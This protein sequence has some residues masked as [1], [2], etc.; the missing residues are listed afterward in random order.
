MRLLI[1]AFILVALIGSRLSG[2]EISTPLGVVYANQEAFFDLVY[3]NETG[4]PVQIKQV[5]VGC[6]CITVL[7]HPTTVTAGSVARI[8]CVYRSAVPGNLQTSVEL[9]GGDATSP[10]AAFK[11]TGFVAE[12]SWLI[13]AREVLA[14]SS[15]QALLVDVRGTEAFAAGHPPHALNLPVFSLKSRAALSSR[16]IVLL[17]EGFAPEA[18]LAEVQVLRE[19]GFKN[20]AVLTGGLVAWVRAGGTLEGT[21]KSATQLSVIAA[22]KFG[23]SNANNPWLCV[24]VGAAQKAKYDSM[25]V[26]QVSTVEELEKKMKE[27]TGPVSGGLSLRMVLVIAEPQI[28]ARIENRFGR[29]QSQQLFYLD[30]GRAALESYQSTQVALARHTDQMISTRPVASR[31]VSRPVVSG[32]CGSCGR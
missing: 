27:W 31:A 15:D 29:D 22:S 11:V 16:R 4:G 20:V 28:Q 12:K 9:L 2:G 23:R 21:M 5:K 6:D 25:P 8:S 19:H 18:L 13:S 32:R 7:T 14:G 24:E 1:T 3:Q 30:G 26:V 17:D 10:L